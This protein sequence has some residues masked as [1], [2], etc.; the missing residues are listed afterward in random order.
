M[1]YRLY[2]IN[3]VLFGEYF[4]EL[5]I[6]PHYEEK[7]EASINDTLIL[8]LVKHLDSCLVTEDSIVN[9]Y[10]FY[11]ADGEFKDKRY[12]LILVVPPDKSY[13]GIRNAYRRSK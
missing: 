3:L 6:D 9:G 4:R 2:W 7:H 12:R 13:L 11:E 5:W 10:S 1:R 8:E